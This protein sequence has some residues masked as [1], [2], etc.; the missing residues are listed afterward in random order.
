MVSQDHSRAA[1]NCTSSWPP[2]SSPPPANTQRLTSPRW[3]CTVSRQ[4]LQLW[5]VSLHRPRKEWWDWR[6]LWSAWLPNTSPPSPSLRST[7]WPVF[8]RTRYV[9]ISWSFT[10]VGQLLRGFPLRSSIL[11]WWLTIGPSYQKQHFCKLNVFWKA[12]IDHCEVYK[13]SSP[14][15]VLCH[16]TLSWDRAQG[17]WKWCLDPFL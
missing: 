1:R 6:T 7:T 14:M 13:W 15:L 5:C 11:T 12:T 2:S 4:I 16:A 10:A 9:L 17:P 8:F 3:T